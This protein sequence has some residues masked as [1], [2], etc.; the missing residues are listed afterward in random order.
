VLAG[1]SLFQTFAAATGNAVYINKKTGRLLGEVS[2]QFIIKRICEM[3]EF[4]AGSRK[5]KE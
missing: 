5:V 4:L 3:A 2:K 1:S